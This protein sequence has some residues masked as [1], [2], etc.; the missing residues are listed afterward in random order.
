MGMV[1][2]L[3]PILQKIDFYSSEASVSTYDGALTFR[4]QSLVTYKS[5]DDS[6]PAAETVAAKKPAEPTKP[7]EPAPK[8]PVEPR[9][10]DEPRKSTDA[11]K[12]KR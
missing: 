6:A 10:P 11:S 8:A 9:A 1:M 2:K 7:D 4:S 5:P 3:G 12:P